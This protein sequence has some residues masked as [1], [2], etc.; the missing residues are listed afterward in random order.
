MLD[1]LSIQDGKVVISQ[2]FL[3]TMLFI[4][5]YAEGTDQEIQ[6]VDGQ[7]RLTTITILFSALSDRFREIG[8]DK[9]SQQLFRYIMTEDD[10]G[11]S[12]RILKSQS[13]YPFFSYYIQDREKNYTQEAVSEEECCIEETYKFFYTQLDEKNIKKSMSKRCGS[14]VVYSSEYID[15]LKAVRDQVLQ[16]TFVSISTTDKKQAN[17]IF[18]ILNAKGKRLAEV[19]LIKNKIFEVLDDV[20]PADFAEEWKKIKNILNSGKETIGLETFYRHFWSARYKKSSKSRLYDD[21]NKYVVPKNKKTYNNFLLDMEKYARYYMLI[22]N[23][24]REDYNNRKEYFPVV[25]MFNI[26]NNYFGIVQVR[27]VEL[28]LL[29]LKEE[30]LIE[31]KSYKKVLSLL[32]TFHFVY[33]SLMRGNPNQI[34]KIYSVFA[35]ESLKCKNKEEVKCLINNKLIEQLVKLLPKREEFIANFIELEYSKKDGPCNIKTKYVL[36]KINAYFEKSELFS[37]DSTIEHI[38]AEA[39]GKESLNI[40]NLILLEGTLNQEADKML[41]SDKVAVYKKSKYLWVKQ[42][43]SENP[44]WKISAIE[45]RAKKLAEF[46]YD[47]IMMSEIKIY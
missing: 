37:D 34:E 10:N 8:E 31:L 18:E 30:E 43:V 2:Y 42:F 35:V 40:G 44:D 13:H 24:K 20:E 12:V 39:D 27:I 6:V 19:D 29:R 45:K 25:Q 15:I 28:A 5:D 17:M 46:Y 1:C 22:L 38:I 11:E 26:L 9:L 23:P 33:N 14:E 21:F 3:G 4:G 47:N 7:Q 36:N 41:Y 16:T 32:V